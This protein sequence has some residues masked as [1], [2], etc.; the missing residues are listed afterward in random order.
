MGLEGWNAAGSV[1]G[2]PLP[3]LGR[4]AK[5]HWGKCLTAVAAFVLDPRTWN[6]RDCSKD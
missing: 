1:I 6:G 2:M 4:A 3:A 5:R